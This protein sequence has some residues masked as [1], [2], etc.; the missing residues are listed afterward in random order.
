MKPAPFRLHRPTTVTD[1][2][3]VFGDYGDEAKV[4]AGGQSLVPLLALRLT[5]FEHL[6]DLN[7]VTALR[8]IAREDNAL[9]V[10]AMVRQAEAEHSDDVA[11]SVQPGDSLAVVGRYSHRME[12]CAAMQPGCNRFP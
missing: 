11:T 4:L 9:R 8:G 5:R 10:G 7:G 3:A 2:T 1:A 6:V 12:L